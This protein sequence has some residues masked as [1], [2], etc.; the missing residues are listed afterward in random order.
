MTDTSR[1]YAAALDA[2]DPLA[3]LRDAF[4]RDDPELI[5][6]DG[7]SL[8]RLPKATAERIASVVR[9]EWGADLIRSWSHWADVPYRVGD[10]IGETLL[11]AAGGQVIVSDSTTVNLYKLAVA[12]LDARRDRN[13]IVTDDDNFPTDR[14]VL[15]GLAA[16]RGLELRVLHTDL[17]EGLD[18]DALREAVGPDTALV[19][20]SHVAYRSG[21]LLDLAAVTEIVHEAGALVLWD[22]CHSAGSVPVRLDASGADLA[23]GCTYKY[24]N[25]GPGSPAFLYV[26][27][28]LQDL[29]QPIWGW[30]GQRDQFAMGP[31]YDPA[32]GIGRFLVGTPPIMAIA[33]VE[34]GVRLLAEA[35]IDRLRAKGEALTGYLIDLAAAWLPDLALA[36]P[37][38]PKR[39]GSHVALR[40]PEAWR[41]AQAMIADR[42]IPDYRTPDRLRLGPAPISTSFTEVWDGLDRLRTIVADRTYERFSSEPARVT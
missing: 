13:V 26:R 19:S 15:E 22:L 14:Y 38:D 29:R 9:D 33:A 42:V 21:A 39:R 5:Y 40:H 36:T 30:F 32:S 18:L 20:L 2:D 16:Q 27:K 3:S 4:V 11:G 25:G 23:V 10:L 8:G 41:M 17:D 31:A 6:L 34:E 28:E 24:L 7:N 1:E 37:A 35:G 12:A